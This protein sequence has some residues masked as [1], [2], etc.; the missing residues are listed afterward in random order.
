M[1][2]RT[3]K[4]QTV[5]VEIIRFLFIVLFF[6]AAVTKLLDYH[7]FVGQIGKSPLLTRYSTWL[8]WLIPSIELIIT[9]ILIIPRWALAG[10]FA[11]F[12]LMTLFTLYI[13]FILSFSRDVPCACGGILNTLDWKEHLVLNIFFVAIGLIGIK[14]H[15]FDRDLTE[16]RIDTETNRQ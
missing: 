12:G 9:I 11:S 5:I 6:Y 15:R 7:G 8:A 1:V 14:L 10:L 3:E 2:T 4:A 16:G 13:I